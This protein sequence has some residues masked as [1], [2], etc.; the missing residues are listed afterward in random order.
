MV[1]PHE[2]AR[3]DHEELLREE[4][5]RWARDD[6]VRDMERWHRPVTEKVVERMQLSPDERILDVGCGDGWTCRLL[7]PL[8]PEGAVV[9]ID[10]ADEM[11][12]LA[13]GRSIEAG[14]HLIRARLGGRDPLGRGLLLAGAQCRVGPLLAL[15]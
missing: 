15:A 4:F 9:G 5:N 2:I 3:L 8:A 13:R 1:P 6:R 7:S 14:Q 11:I 10:V 12:A